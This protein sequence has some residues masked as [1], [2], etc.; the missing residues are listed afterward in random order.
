MFDITNYSDH[1]TRPGHVVFRF[2]DKSRAEHFEQLLKEDTIWYES[3]IDRDDD[4]T[5]YL[6]GIKIGDQKKAL[7]ANYLVSAKFRK[8]T[9]PNFYARLV[10]YLVAIGVI[11]LAI[12]GAIIKN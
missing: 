8:K 6:F 12:I 11:S 7:Q 5:T 2:Y 1:P 10:I 4:K 3:S 9:I